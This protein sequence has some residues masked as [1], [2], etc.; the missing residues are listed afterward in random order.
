M[1]H[2]LAWPARLVNIGALDN[3]RYIYIKQ[4]QVYVS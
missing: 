2:V 4:K 3:Q 1:D